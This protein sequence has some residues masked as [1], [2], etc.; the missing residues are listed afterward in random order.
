MWCS[1][2]ATK[3]LFDKVPKKGSVYPTVHGVETKHF[4]KVT[5]E[6]VQMV[7]TNRYI[8]DHRKRRHGPILPVN[9]IAKSKTFHIDLVYSTKISSNLM[10]CWRDKLPSTSRLS[11]HSVDKCTRY[12]S[13]NTKGAMVCAE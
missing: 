6:N 5:N 3:A 7:N 1:L 11:I 10:H 4:A 12:T 2:L 9:I 13:L 8:L